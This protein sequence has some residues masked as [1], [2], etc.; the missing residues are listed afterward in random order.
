MRALR[1]KLT[2]LLCAA[3]L[4]GAL[5]AAAAAAANRGPLPFAGDAG[6][7]DGEPLAVFFSGENFSGLSWTVTEE[8]DYDLRKNFDLPNDCVMSAAVRPGF[9]V[10]LYEHIRFEGGSLA[11]G[12]DTAYL[13]DFWKRQASSLSVWAGGSG[14]RRRGARD[15]LAKFTDVPQFR[16]FNKTR[17]SR[18]ELPSAVR[19]WGVDAAKMSVLMEAGKSEWIR[20]NDAARVASAAEILKILGAG[21]FDVSEWT[22]NLLAQQISNFY[23]WRSGGTIFNAACFMTGVMPD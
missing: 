19:A 2:V 13:P 9:E 12:R 18:E 14:S 11:L 21:G 10:T 20:T 4:Y 23:D 8:G 7:A 6:G 5:T 16:D 22:S 3:V 15:W 1:G 17:R